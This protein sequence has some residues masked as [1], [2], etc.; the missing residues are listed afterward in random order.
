MMPS[1]ARPGA[2]GG[3]FARQCL[4]YISDIPHV[5]IKEKHVNGSGLQHA[6]DLM[7]TINGNKHHPPHTSPPLA[8]P[9]N[10][11]PAKSVVVKKLLKEAEALSSRMGSFEADGH[12]VFRTMPVVGDRLMD[13]SPM[14]SIV[15]DG[16]YALSV[17]ARHYHINRSYLELEKS[18]ANLKAAYERVLPEYAHDPDDEAFD[19]L[20]YTSEKC[21]AAIDR[22]RMVK[23]VQWNAQCLVAEETER[24]A[25]TGVYN[26]GMRISLRWSPCSNIFVII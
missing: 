13:S 8:P 19:V 6:S 23:F 21:V 7:G 20:T 4:D 2:T 11:P 18:A 24:R 16:A 1:T 12:L 14:S 26:N 22:L 10:A 25:K 5:S 3:M 9:A 15:N 17:T